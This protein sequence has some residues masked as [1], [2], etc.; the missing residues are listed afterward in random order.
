MKRQALLLLFSLVTVTAAFSQEICNNGID[1]DGDGFIDCFDKKCANNAACA[2]SFLGNDVICQAKPAAFPQFS[3][4]LKWQ[5]P[6]KTTNHLNRA[7]VGDLDRDGIPEVIV[8]EI[9]N[10][11]IYIL[12]GKDGTVKKSLKVGFSLDR[13][14][15]IG[16]I[17]NS[18]CAWIFVSGGNYVYAYDCN[19]NFKWK[20]TL[21]SASPTLMG[22]ADFDG[23]GKSEIYCRDE[24]LA[25]ESG[26]RIVK[27]TNSAN[28][29][30]AP[31]AVD[32]LDAAGNV[33]GTGDNKLELISGCNIF[34]VNLGARTLN[35]GS[36][37]L[38]KSAANYF[39]WQKNGNTSHTSVADY[40]QDGKLDVIASGSTGAQS[41]NATVFF[42][43]VQN[44]VVKTY[45]DANPASVFIAGCSNTSGTYY[46]NGWQNGIG[47]LNI[48]DIDGDGKL[49]VS[50][51]SGK[52][53]YALD[54]NFNQKWRITVNEETSGY[55]GCTVY[56]FNGDGAAEVV[57]RDEQFLYII[58][59]KDGTT[60]T[61][62]QCIARTNFEY[63]IVSDIDGDGTTEL[64]VT[65]GFDDAL[66]WSN[67][68][69][70]AYSQNSC[71][72]V[73]QSA[74][75]PWVPS[76]KLWNQH[77][78]FNVNVNDD[79]TIPKVMQKQTAIF[80]T[81]VCTVTSNRPL[82]SFLNQSPFLDSKGC[83]TYAS[84]DLVNVQALFQVQPP[85]CPNTDFTVTIGVKN[86]GDVTI[87][88]NV[89]VTFYNGDPT[90]A[91][92]TKL[93]T[94]NI[95]VNLSKNQT[96]TFT[97]LTVT[98]TGGSFNLYIS[99]ND[100]GTSVPTPI[101]LPNTPILECDYGNV[102]SANVVPKSVKIT[103][104]KV[105][106]NVKCVGATVPDNGAATASV[107][108]N[109]VDYNFY[110]FNGA[111]AGAPNYTGVSY[112]GLAAG[113]YKVFATHKT[114]NCNSDT[115]S[116]TIIRVD[117]APM[118]AT[119][120]VDK[121]NTSCSS[122]NGQM[123]AVVNGGDPIND[124]TYKWY[125]G[126]DIFTSPEVGVGYIASN[127]KGGKTY[128]VLVT[129]IASGCQT[130]TSL[131]VPDNTSSPVV[132]ATKTDAVCVPA[133]SG[134]ASATVGGATAGYTFNWYIG[135]VTKPS[136]DFTGATY[137]S[138]PA[139]SY[140][141][142]ATENTSGCLSLPVTV[143]VNLPPP[144]T[145]NTSMLTQQTM[146]NPATPNGSAT[147]DVGGVTAGYTFNWFTGQSTA[148]ANAIAGPTNLASGIYTVKATNDAT[149]CTATNEVTITQ[150]LTYPV[151]SLTPSPNSTCDPTKGSNAFNGSVSATVTYNGN[152][153]VDPV[154][155]NFSLVWHNGA[156][157]TDPV[158]GGNTTSISQLN[159]G[160][161]T[162]VVTRTDLGCAA[163]PVTATVTNTTTLPAL[164]TSQTPSTNCDPLLKNG[165]AEVTQVNGIGVGFTANFT[166]QWH[167]GVGTGS[168]I[169]G[170]TNA[171]LS[172]VQGGAANNYT[173]LVTDKT[174]GCQNTA[175]VLVADAKVLP[176]LSLAKT[177]NTVCNPA[178]TSPAVNYNGSVTAT[179]T[180]QVGGLGN[181][182]FTFGG[183]AGAGTQL[184]S[185]NQNQYTVLNG[186]ATAYTAFTTQTPTGCVSSTSSIVVNNVLALP[187]I[188]TS[189]TA[190]TN[191]VAGKED[192][193]ARVTTVD[194]TAVGAA[195][196]YTYSWS[197]PGAPA[198]PV[199]P[200]P[201]TSNTSQVIKV[202]GGAGYNYTVT[203]THQ[204]NGCQN[205]ATLNVPDAKV[206]P[207]LSLAEV[208][209]TVCN[210]GLTSPAVNYNGSVTATVTNQLG[211]LANY[212]FVF[213]GGAGAGTQLASPNQ[214]QYTV[215]NGGATA[216]T[217]QA[218]QTSTGCVSSVANI[219]VNNV[220]ALPVIVTSATSSTNCVAGKEDGQARVTTVDGTAVGAAVGYTY[221][222]TGPV[223]PAF[224]VAGNATKT[225]AQLTQVQGG[226]GYDYAVQVT[227]QTNGCQNTAAVN[228]PDAKVLPVLTLA[229]ADNTVCDPTLTSPAVAFNGSVTTTITNQLG[230][231]GNYTFAYAGGGAQT[232]GGGS[233]G[234]PTANVW[235]QLNGG[236]TA[237]TVQ[238]TQTP[239]GCIS[240]VSS[241]VV[242]NAP[243]AMTMATNS[244]G[245]TNCVA[246]K[247]DGQ[248]VV[249]QVD[250]AAAVSA[251]FVYAWTGPGA[252]AF[253]VTNGTNNANTLDL[254]KLQGGAGYDY[255]VLVTR[256]SDGC[257]LSKL[258]NVPDAK[259]L[260]TLTLSK[261][262]NT[263]C[264]PT[265]TSPAAAFSGSV[266]A[267]ITN[268]LG[269][270]G[271]YTFAYG[272]G[273]SAG[274]KGSPTANAWS[275]L[276]G[277]ATAYTVQAT[278]TPTGCVSAVASIMV[279][280]A[281][282]V[283]TIATSATSSTNCV[284]GKED[285]QT[286]VTQVDG[287]AAVAA[288]FVYAWTGPGAFSVNNGTNNAN[289]K[290]LIKLQGG[291][292]YDYSVVVT[293][294]TDGC[295]VT[296]AVNV[297]DAKI[298]PT[299][300]L[301]KVDNT[302]C[303]PALTS[304]PTAYTGSVTTTI[305]NQL[306]ALS[307]YSFTYTDVAGQTPGGGQPGSPTANVWS[308]LNGG[309][310]AYT[311]QVTQTPT[312]CVSAIA[313]TTLLSNAPLPMTI[314]TSS[315]GSTNCIAGKEDGKASVTQVD[316][317]PAVAAGF[318]Y[319]WTG[320]AAPAFAVNN[321]TNNANTKDLIKLQ[322][323][324]GYDY[325]VVV[326]RQTDGCQVTKAVNVSDNKAIPV[327]T[328]TPQP[329]TICDPSKT[330]PPVT[331]DGQV[332]AV[333]N[334]AGNYTGN[335]SGDFTFTWNT[336]LTGVGQNLLLNQDV[337]TYSVTAVHTNTGCTSAL[338][339]TNVTSAKT[340][341]TITTDQSPSTNC[342]GGTADGIAKVLD[343]TPHGKNY[344]YKWFDGN[345]TAGAPGP[346]TLNTVATTNNYTGV[347]GG[348]SGASLIQ[349]TVEVTI[350][351]TGCQNSQS[352]GVADDKKVPILGPLKETDNTICT[353]IPDGTANVDTGLATAVVYRG[354][355]QPAPLYPGFTFAWTGPAAFTATGTSIT[356]RGAG[357]YSLTTTNTVSNCTSNPVTVTIKDNL[358]TPKIDVVP[359]P[360]T[361]CDT[362]SPNG[363]LSASIDE[364]A[365]GGGAVVTAG[366][367]Y[368]WVNNVTGATL[369][370][371]GPVPANAISGQKGNQN[372]TISVIRN[373]TQCQNSQTVF[374]DEILTIPTAIVA[375]TNLSL[376]TPNYNGKLV[377]TPAP[378]AIASYDY[379]WYD[380]G[381]AA[382]ENAVI[383]V[384]NAG[385]FG[386]VTTNTYDRLVSGDY[387]VVVRDKTTKCVS[388]QVISTVANNILA[389]NPVAENTT[390]PTACSVLDG[391]LTA[392]VHLKSL[393]NFSALAATDELTIGAAIGLA[394]NDQVII[395]R[396]GALTLPAPLLT[397]QTYFVKT[398]VGGT[399]IT[400]SA[401]AGGATID[402]T[403][404]GD[405]TI[406]D[407]TT[408]GY[409]FNWFNSVPSGIIPA[410]PISYYTFPINPPNFGALTPSGS[411]PSNVYSGITNGLYS[412]E[413][414]D[415]ATGCKN[416]ISHTLPFL[417]SHAV[418]KIS[419]TNSTK[420]APIADDGSITILIEDPA[421]APVG[422]NYDILLDGV[423]KVVGAVQFT[424]YTVSTA[425]APGTY[426]ISVKQNYGSACQLDQ[427]VVIGRDALP[428]LVD[429]ASAIV[430]NTA[431]DATVYNGQIQISVAQDPADPLVGTTYNIDMAPDPNNGFPLAAQPSG[432]Y[433]AAS[434]GPNS[435][436]F[437]V[438]ASSGCSTSKT[439][440]LNDNPSISQL[441][442]ANVAVTDAEYCTAALEKSAQA[443]VSQVNLIGGGAEILDDYEFNWYSA[444]TAFTAVAATDL[445]TVPGSAF[446]VNN[447]VLLNLGGGTFPVG[448][449]PGKEFFVKTVAGTVISLSATM[450]G[451]TVDVTAD[452]SGNISS[453]QLSALGVSGA[454]KGGEEFSNVGAPLPG[455]PVWK[456]TY[457][458]VT[459]KKTDASATGGIGCAS[460]PITL[461]INDKSVSPSITLTPSGDASCDPAFFEGKIQVDVTT[462]SGPGMAQTYGY[463]WVPNGGAGQPTN[464]ASGNSGVAN[465]FTG[466][467]DGSYSLTATNDI[468][469]CPSTLST[470]IVRDTPPV[471]TVSATA[472]N[473]TFCSLPFNGSINGIQA[474]VNG[475]G[476]TVDDFDYV[477]FRTDLLPASKVLDGQNAAIT[478]EDQLTSVTYAAIGLDKYFVKAVRK[479]P[480]N[481]VEAT[482]AA[483]A[484]ASGGYTFNLGDYIKLASGQIYKFTGPLKTNAGD[485]TLSGAISGAGCESAALR[486]D[487]LDDRVYPQVSLATVSSTSCDANFDGQITV[488]A[489]TA[490]GPG[491]GANYNFVWTSD[492]DMGG[493]A[494]SASNSATNNTA[495]PFSTVNTDLIGPQAG[496]FTNP[497]TVRVT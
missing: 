157:A 55:T 74:G 325:T 497:Y 28:A 432:N 345:S 220:L 71:V 281:P 373:S 413:V 285:G 424:N 496:A 166:Y 386:T 131:A 104:T 39:Y 81:G 350:L 82:N 205:T 246:G 290:D 183:G 252:P 274:V 91:G 445:L 389:I 355:N 358:F 322:G 412:V 449:S 342:V 307:N 217:A 409:T 258:V 404:D 408:A 344:D 297:P 135:A 338:T 260:P 35:S 192:G 128:T 367:T 236:A 132:S 222:W 302:I 100:A 80:S 227:H 356:Q 429:L 172:N 298:L 36:L 202:Q 109:T 349:Y 487:I 288:G 372:Y 153:V 96:Q 237:Y 371:P 59:G 127:L 221:L 75:V 399:V 317:A 180:N 415:N 141:V 495:S 54:E 456:G 72:R 23:D 451:P 2:G 33:A 41:A 375:I 313:S 216:Y 188:V 469:G 42:W 57:Y 31:I 16:N 463:A 368:T 228:V 402:L 5:S 453:N 479:S 434:L 209:N 359:T 235:S 423:T 457:Y 485:Y 471:F 38:K 211:G 293:R 234:S 52:Y 374:L 289:T 156:L 152:P 488:T 305:T 179:V 79:L 77:G 361:S 171:K 387:T 261:V 62:Q 224:S 165:I 265:L 53:M 116:V 18:N 24:I 253:P 292:G 140:T 15:M 67:F 56:D 178:L 385:L 475:I 37:T 181:Y 418:I 134:S 425:L 133:N 410:S 73:F 347:Q 30:Q 403:T 433:P 249:T 197:G 390:I 9:E 111:V 301:S 124:Y 32:I 99:L 363:A 20:S 335:V 250:G 187:V 95:P 398:I 324:A 44:N 155:A 233:K 382:D 120:V 276:N 268:Q 185:P 167:T 300:T 92:A 320:P 4:K 306:G 421:G 47:R 452:G 326:T 22:L 256:Q 149:G 303:N 447:K 186:G 294:Q 108:G 491:A 113:T 462:A 284:A 378:G 331:F 369:A 199:S 455:S 391:K 14:P 466:L 119:I 411:N 431:C 444:G 239:T 269:G 142:T 213:G 1:D 40:N 60:N 397:D 438:T 161:Y 215:L 218:T 430:P 296:K 126:N 354:A 65:C 327:L 45:I 435:Y 21:L 49:N 441:L 332:S 346:T 90:K 175:T 482:I 163:A 48:A 210:P 420:C 101:V 282:A 486:K 114:A 43:D 84:P 454:V 401:T 63:P 70:I 123:H 337:G 64:C 223:A 316:G 323:G 219:V 93:N 164:T 240:A 3:M 437:S 271:N 467:N 319:V 364:T 334:S 472:N 102:I 151:V 115:A 460:A 27:G 69:S 207:V 130:I 273:V 474:F 442:A 198:F 147:A 263:I 68:C 6:N 8:N 243:A 177:D 384:N 255:T 476:G 206:L 136:P 19:L 86:Q 353:G 241:I 446:A 341:P 46:K 443:I 280:N 314:A 94:V 83:P 270:L 173:V 360:Q 287:A 254:I 291:A 416:F 98:G 312:G 184:A 150:N 311:V 272:G 232:P 477:W 383:A 97:S 330:N 470:T 154:G 333:V 13:D 118:V 146:C 468:T 129:D 266:T 238:V 318:T 10:D 144:F 481:A 394:V 204:T 295:Q 191:C 304:P 105:N 400:L 458:G 381:N 309:S 242:G 122:P 275:Q 406:T 200:V 201:N 493:A 395:G 112:S 407:F 85:T 417:G 139:G 245:S 58:N 329:N 189:N 264:D 25:A 448:L 436:T 12:N 366:Y 158:I 231:L 87:N 336:G 225:L 414:T 362:S 321:G 226:A 419:K 379:F 103:A 299:L 208:D 328:L 251:G 182:T 88:T 439:F 107:G 396:N 450:G 61:Q 473:Q 110:W 196:G 492:P 190:S 259:V 50:Y 244:I 229:K 195:V 376:C 393:A 278:Q 29:S 480:I 125:E 340:L 121:P 162:L 279:S 230:A 137:N 117:K 169:A 483:F 464:S 148:P 352:V 143:S 348:L 168:P 310:G 176:T 465:M 247:E 339:S 308:Q 78:Y 194:G 478:V 343:V 484:A 380:G 427:D 106:D 357:V 388:T 212:T 160:S 11:Y 89:P 214:N 7:S 283:M 248:A 262:D 17:D 76:R 422:A 138:I 392:A 405:G 494:Y 257:Q 428:P 489:T 490:S 370:G 170:A 66:A 377:A 174:T 145:V 315:T 203:V 193:Q 461:T 286:S 426:V 51:I 365:I 34:S 459:T 267:T 26:I 277:G 351:Q 159:G 440:T